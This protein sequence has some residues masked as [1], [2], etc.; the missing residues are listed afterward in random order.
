MP[1]YLM[2]TMKFD[3]YLT[4]DLRYG[5]GSNSSNRDAQY[6]VSHYNQFWIPYFIIVLIL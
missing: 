2:I 6:I 3:T 5:F 4:P 1:Q